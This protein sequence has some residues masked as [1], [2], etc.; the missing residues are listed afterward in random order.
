MK[1]FVH[2]ELVLCRHSC[3][4]GNDSCDISLEVVFPQYGNQKNN[5]LYIVFRKCFYLFLLKL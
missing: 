3:N 1:S 2:V 5:F 4:F